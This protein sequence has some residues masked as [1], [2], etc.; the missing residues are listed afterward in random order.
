MSLTDTINADLKEAMKAREKARLNTLRMVKTALKNQEIESGPLDDEAAMNVL[1]KLVKQ[2]K[3]SIAQFEKAGRD[4]LAEIEKQELAILDAY[5]PAAP[6]E[7]E[8]KKAVSEVIAELNADSMKAMGAVMK[9]LKDRFA[10][11]PVDGK[12]LSTLVRQALS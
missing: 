11:R 7:D 3:D 5:L 4:D 1:L 8:M 6:S 2:R 12:T 9:E 10:G